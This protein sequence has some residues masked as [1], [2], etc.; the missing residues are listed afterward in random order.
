MWFKPNGSSGFRIEHIIPILNVKGISR[1]LAFYVDILGFERAEWSD[2]DFS[3]ISRGNAQLYLC[4]QGQGSP[5]TWIWIGFDGDIH[6]LHRE[7]EAKGV[8]IKMPPTK[9]AYALEMRILDPDENVLRLGTNP[10][11]ARQK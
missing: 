1:S 3:G 2:D 5:G 9:F 7:L 8:I 10:E 6:A 4:R 11:D